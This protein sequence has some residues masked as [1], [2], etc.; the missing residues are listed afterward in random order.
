MKQMK[1][2]DLRKLVLFCLR[3]CVCSGYWSTVGSIDTCLSRARLWLCSW[4]VCWRTCW[5]TAPSPMMRAPSSAWAVPSTSWWDHF[6]LP[7]PI[8][9]NARSS[10]WI[11]SAGLCW[12]GVQLAQIRNLTDK[13]VKKK[14]IIK[15]KISVHP[16]SMKLSSS[17]GWD[18]L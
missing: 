15:H 6:L 7:G 12:F 1:C 10:V 13:N 5:P 11:F 17:L 4:A 14:N 3:V 9:P 2:E 8:I 16:L 18:L